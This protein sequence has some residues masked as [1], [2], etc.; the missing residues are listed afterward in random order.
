MNEN[1]TSLNINNKNNLVQS[2]NNTNDTVVDNKA[3]LS[4]NNESIGPNDIVIEEDFEINM[5]IADVSDISL[6][7]TSNNTPQSA[8]KVELASEQSGNITF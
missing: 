3:S 5:D 4:E 8:E 2:S 6:S 7:S 1:E